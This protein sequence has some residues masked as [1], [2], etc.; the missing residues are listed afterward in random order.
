MRERTIAAVLYP[1]AI[2]FHHD[3]IAGTVMV[4]ERAVT[5]KTIDIRFSFMAWIILTFLI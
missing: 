1:P 5:E 3:I 2:F 4:I